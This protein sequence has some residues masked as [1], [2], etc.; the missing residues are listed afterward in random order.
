MRGSVSTLL[1]EAHQEV[2]LAVLLMPEAAFL[3]LGCLVLPA[4]LISL[5]AQ[6]EFGVWFDALRT[7]G[8]V[9]SEFSLCLLL[10]WNHAL[11]IIRI[12]FIR[13]VITKTLALRTRFHVR[14]QRTCVPATLVTS[15]ALKLF[16]RHLFSE[17]IS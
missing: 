10:F 14:L 17:S 2:D 15:R 7:C 9:R 13:I 6:L 3:A 1:T 12:F 8:F 4:A 5:D 11:F 16:I